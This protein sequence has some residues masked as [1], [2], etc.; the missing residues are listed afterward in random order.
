[1][2]N[3]RHAHLPIHPLRPESGAQPKGSPEPS[4]SFVS[5]AKG[6]SEEP[7]W[8]KPGGLLTASEQKAVTSGDGVELPVLRSLNTAEKAKIC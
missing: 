1:M 3:G 2:A 6:A 4:P 5:P 8:G 7:L